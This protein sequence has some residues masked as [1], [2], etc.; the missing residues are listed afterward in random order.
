VCWLITPEV[1]EQHEAAIEQYL[2]DELEYVVVET[3]EPCARRRFH[4]PR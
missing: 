2:R 3:Y 1:E 4:A